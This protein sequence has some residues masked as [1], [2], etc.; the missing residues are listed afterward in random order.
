MCCVRGEVYIQTV[1]WDMSENEHRA[2]PLSEFPLMP[3]G[4]FDGGSGGR[5]GE[6]LPLPRGPAHS[7][8]AAAGVRGGLVQRHVSG[9]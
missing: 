2:A 1:G 7:Q 4:V 3:Q 6:L 5:R 9:F 8:P